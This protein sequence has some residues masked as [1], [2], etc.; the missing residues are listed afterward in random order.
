MNDLLGNDNIISGGLTRYETVLIKADKAREKGSEPIDNEFSD[1]FISDITETNGP[2]LFNGL[3]VIQF[4][5]EHNLGFIDFIGNGFS[6]KTVSNEVT[7]R[8]AN[9]MPV[10]VKEN[11]L[12]TIFSKCF[13]GFNVID[14]I[15]HLRV[16]NK[17]KESIVIL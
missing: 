6:L 7:N 8:R 15:P 3:R 2:K 10:F 5:N 11:S 4:G 1:G 14:R 16:G 13:K 17:G 12:K 9:D